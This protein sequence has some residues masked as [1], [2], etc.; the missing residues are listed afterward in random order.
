[1]VML[2]KQTDGFTLLEVMIAVGILAM[3]LV[4]LLHAH[5]TN[6]RMADHT[7]LKTTAVLLAEKRIAGLESSGVRSIGMR[8]GDFMELHPG[9][10][11]RELISPVRV[12]N[13]VLTGLSRVEVVV[14]WKEGQREENVRL[15]TYVSG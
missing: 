7:G 2:K 11:W 13:Q 1:M 6:L 9:F 4:V 15:V 14:S 3:A 5:V 8:E 12:G 10:F